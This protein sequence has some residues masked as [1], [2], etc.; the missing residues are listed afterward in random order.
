MLPE[1]K[2]KTRRLFSAVEK[3]AVAIIVILILVIILLVFNR[4]LKEYYEIFKAW[5]ENA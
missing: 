1:N 4:Q 2:N 3:I 5:Y